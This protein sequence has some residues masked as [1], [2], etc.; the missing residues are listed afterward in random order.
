MVSVLSLSMVDCEFESG[1]GSK[2]S[3]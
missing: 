2:Q 3:L 1:V